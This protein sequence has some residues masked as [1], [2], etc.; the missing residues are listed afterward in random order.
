MEISKIPK[1]ALNS[2]FEDLRY[3]QIAHRLALETTRGTVALKTQAIRK[4]IRKIDQLKNRLLQELVKGKISAVQFQ[5][6]LIPSLKERPALL[7]K[8][9]KIEEPYKPKIKQYRRVIEVIDFLLDAKTIEKKGL[10]KAVDEPNET[11]LKLAEN[12]R[13]SKKSN[14][15]D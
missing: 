3:E 5:K 4:D 6:Q 10:P 7:E 14:K 12:L 2:S 15:T 11:F 8:K 13:E 9:R 1:N